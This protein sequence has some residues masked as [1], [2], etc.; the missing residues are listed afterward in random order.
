MN[1]PSATAASSTRAGYPP[2]IETILDRHLGPGPHKAA[3]RNVAPDDPADSLAGLLDDAARD[4]ARAIADLGRALR[5]TRADLDDALQELEIGGSLE[6]RVGRHNLP[7]L[8][9]RYTATLCHLDA[10]ARTYAA[11]RTAIAVDRA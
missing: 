1:Q 4:A 3:L 9:A 2:I 5:G 7:G 6:H 8:A 11:Y 10:A